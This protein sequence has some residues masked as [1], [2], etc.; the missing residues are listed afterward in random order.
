MP[1]L[2]SPTSAIKEFKR[3]L[4]SAG[5]HG[6]LSYLNQ[7]TPH[8]FTGIYRFDGDILR[9]EFLFDKYEPDTRKGDDAPMEATYC[10]L[11]GASRQPLE[12]LDSATDARVIGVVVTPVVSYC[13]VLISNN[14]GEPYG[15]L[16]HFDMA[17]CEV[18]SSDLPLLQTGAKLLFDRLH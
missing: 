8:R 7:R 12:I 5:V 6:A 15:T 4:L 16:C 18:S 1:T 14:D 3:I 9:N 13:G 17:R 11:V 10:S 2:I